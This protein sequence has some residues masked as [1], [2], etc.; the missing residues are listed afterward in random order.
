MQFKIEHTSVLVTDLQRTI[1]FYEQAFQLTVRREK[2]AADR[3]IVFLGNDQAPMQIEVIR[4]H[5]DASQPDLGDNP[6]H[7]AFRTD[8]FEASRRLHED[9]GCI[10]HELPEFGVYFVSDPDGYLCE[11][12]PVRK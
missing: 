12:M 9:M 4:M 1:A 8:D 7:L 6:T 2:A 3:D 5:G 10:H 11:V